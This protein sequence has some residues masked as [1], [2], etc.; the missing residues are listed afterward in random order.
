MFI[1]KKKFENAIHEAKREVAE[2]WE[3]KLNEFEKRTW[4]DQDRYRTAEEY[5]TRFNAIE[6]RIL[7]LEKT[8]GLVEETPVCPYVTKCSF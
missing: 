1:S 6:K 3:R 7:A 2:Q 8:H 4:E 5:R